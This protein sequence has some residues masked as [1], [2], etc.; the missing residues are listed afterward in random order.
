[1]Q[2]GIVTDSTCD[3]PTN[4]AEK[5]NIYIVPTIL[6]IDGKDYKDGE[7][8]SRQEFYERLPNMK[9]NPSTAAPS[10]GAFQEAYDS[11]FNQGCHRIITLTAATKLSALYSIAILAA[12]DYNSRIEVIDSGQTSV[13]LGFQAIA[14]AEAAVR[15]AGFEEIMDRINSTKQRVK[16]VAMLDTMK[17]LHRSGRISWAT[18]SIGSLLKIKVFI[19]LRDGEVLRYGQKRTRSKGIAHIINLI[20]ELGPLERL[21]IMHTNAEFDA[22]YILESVIVPIQHDPLL[23]HATTIIGTHVGSRGLGFAAVPIE[24]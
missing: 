10:V 2:I 16:V 7:A 21:S 12:K 8:I 15:G 1:M 6:I 23:I 13:G 20:D 22:N 24:R 4:I 17:Q 9:T 3:I 19:E 14:G 11:L 18:S 5:L